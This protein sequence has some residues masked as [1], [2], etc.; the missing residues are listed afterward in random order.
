M[1]IVTGW[2]ISES[3]LSYMCEPAWRFCLSGMFWFSGFLSIPWLVV[4]HLELFESLAVSLSY[5]CPRRSFLNPDTNRRACRKLHCYHWGRQHTSVLYTRFDS[6]VEQGLYLEW[7]SLGIQY[8]M[9]TKWW[10]LLDSSATVTLTRMPYLWIRKWG[11]SIQLV[12]MYPS[13]GG[14][15]TF[16]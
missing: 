3:M 13:S 16:H 4:D 10:I 1:R 2:L 15:T 11:H 7:R 8:S 14:T 6:Q 5:D 12:R 9:G